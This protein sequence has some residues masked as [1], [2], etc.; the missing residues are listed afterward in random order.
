MK[1]TQELKIGFLLLVSIIISYFLGNSGY[2][3]SEYIA[4][5]II[6]AVL[7]Y[8]LFLVTKNK[9]TISMKRMV[10]AS[11]GSVLLFRVFVDIMGKS[12]AGRPWCGLDFLEPVFYFV[13]A[14]LIVFGYVLVL[15]MVPFMR[16]IIKQ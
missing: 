14:W 15:R 16:K 9:K 13:V 2:E 7:I 11:L 3:L 8:S 10:F 5:A 12:C 1:N 4:V 6:A